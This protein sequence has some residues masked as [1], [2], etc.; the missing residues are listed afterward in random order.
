MPERQGPEKVYLP[1]GDDARKSQCHREGQA[2]RK[3]AHKLIMMVDFRPDMPF[4]RTT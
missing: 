1:I 4:V 3:F 2:H